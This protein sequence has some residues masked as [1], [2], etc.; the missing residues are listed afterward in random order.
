M[1]LDRK[2]GELKPG[3]TFIHHD[4]EWM[5]LDHPSEAEMKNNGTVFN[6]V[7]TDGLNKLLFDEGTLVKA[8]RIKLHI[9]DLRQGDQITMDRNIDIAYGVSTVLKVWEDKGYRHATIARPMLWG[10]SFGTTSPSAHVSIEKYDTMARVGD[11]KR[12]EYYYLVGIDT[13]ALSEAEGFNFIADR[14]RFAVFLRAN[15]DKREMAELL[16]TP[17]P[18]LREDVGRIIYGAVK[19]REEVPPFPDRKDSAEA[20]YHKNLL[21]RQTRDNDLSDAEKRYLAVQDALDLRFDS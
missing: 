2:F 8:T 16:I 19:R 4:V 12:N 6:A 11:Y 10:S 15:G 7:S 14:F 5:V 1:R 17:Y 21:D 20:E 18:S 3:D 9:L 13:H